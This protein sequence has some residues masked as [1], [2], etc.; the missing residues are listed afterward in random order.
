MTRIFNNILPALTFFMV[1]CMGSSEKTDQ[2]TDTPVAGSSGKVN[3]IRMK[4]DGKLW[5]ADRDIFGAF[6]P[7]GYNKAI[8]MSGSK[9]P[10]DKNEQVFT[11]NLFNTSG[12]GV[13][14]ITNGNA[15]NNVVQLANLSPEHFLYG[16]MMGFR[17]KVTV[18]K[19]SA[20][21]AVIE[22]VFE[23]ELTGNA[24]DKLKITEGSFLYKE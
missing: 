8:I 5:E 3:H 17:L 1:S 12:P 2:Q 7:K 24:G 21:P 4:I 18:T 22:A 11:L 14:D 20:N 6:H 15:D 19:A 10:K 13:F 9:G 23:G 16:S